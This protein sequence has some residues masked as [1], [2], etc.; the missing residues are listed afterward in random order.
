[1]KTKSFKKAALFLV[2]AL[3]LINVA[4]N[5][6]EVL[7]TPTEVQTTQS[8]KP[9]S[10]RAAATF[11]GLKFGKSIENYMN[12]KVAGYGYN[13]IHDGLLVA[14]GGNGWAR[15][16]FE[17]N[18]TKHSYQ[19]RQGIASSAKFVTALATIAL[20]EK[21]NIPLDSPV[22]PYLPVTWKPTANF[23]KITFERL[24][25]HQT[26]LNYGTTGSEWQKF[27]AAVEDPNLVDGT[28]R[29][30]D[31]INFS[32]MAIIL[33]YIGF[34]ETNS[35]TTAELAALEKNSD[36]WYTID[37]LGLR[38]RNIVR[39]YVFKP[40]QMQY[41][42]VADYAAWNNYGLMPAENGTKGYP[43]ANGNEPGTLKGDS[44]INGG[45]GGLYISPNEF[46]HIQS[47]AAEGKIISAENYKQM[48]SK[49]LGLDGV[50]NGVYGKYYWKNGGANNHETMIFDMG[51]TQICVFTNTNLSEIGNKPSIIANAYDAAWSK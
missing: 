40:S 18:P 7:P 20:L 1:M 32:L 46:G 23:K 30:Y 5:D 24:L 28:T 21:Y 6:A 10:L 34:K 26:R 45:A 22:Y 41:W 48:K 39:N 15:K 12:G 38:F 50:V 11:D 9:S 19:Q 3:A 37:A 42:S 35:K 49:L 36:T 16:Q 8:E 31:N 13:V 33:P 47:A 51:R 25:A 14:A 44:R 4:C 43:S 2:S 29:Q 27:K 17:S